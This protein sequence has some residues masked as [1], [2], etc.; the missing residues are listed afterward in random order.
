MSATIR[1]AATD[2]LEDPSDLL[3]HC[4][5]ADLVDDDG[6][7]DPERIAGA[8]HDLIASRP[9]LARRRPTGDIDQGARPESATVDLAGLLRERAI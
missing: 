7:P 3:R 2:I 8:A 1:E 5:E 9:H 6:M 4:D